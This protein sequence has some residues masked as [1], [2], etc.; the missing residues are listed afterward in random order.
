[1]LPYITRVVDGRPAQRQRWSFPRYQLLRRDQRVFSDLGLFG[2]ASINLTDG[3]NPSGWPANGSRPATSPPSGFPAL[4][5]RTFLPE[6][7]S[8]PARTPPRCSAMG[9]GMRRYGGDRAAVGRTITLEGT[10]LRSWASCP[11]ASRVSP[12]QRSSGP[13][14]PWP[15]HSAIAN[16]SRPTRTSFRRL[17]DQRGRVPSGGAGPSLAV[18][19]GRISGGP[20]E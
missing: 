18:L 11:K 4:I 14:W 16:S 3:P 15:R 1:M 7:D 8:I 2:P 17:R 9:C 10:P 5:G 12:A 20:A 6:E 13:R 19:G